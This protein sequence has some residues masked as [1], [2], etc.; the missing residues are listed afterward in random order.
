MEQEGEMRETSYSNIALKELK[1]IIPED[2]YEDKLS[3]YMCELEPSF[4]GFIEQYHALSKVIPKHYT[5]ID[6]GCY[7]AAQCYFFRNHEK[8]IGVDSDNM[9]GESEKLER[10]KTDNAVHHKSKI[11]DFIKN[12]GDKDTSTTFAICNYVPDEEAQKM[13]REKFSNCFV[14]YPH[15]FEHKIVRRAKEVSHD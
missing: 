14:F 2:E 7:M 8:Y 3:Q 5:V 12:M 13:V 10:F 6:F 15:G 9:M 1:T 11:Q 4:L